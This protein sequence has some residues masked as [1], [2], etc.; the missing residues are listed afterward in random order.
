[1]FAEITGRYCRYK[2]VRWFCANPLNRLIDLEHLKVNDKIKRAVTHYYVAFRSG[3][4]LLTRLSDEEFIW[5]L[6]IY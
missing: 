4:Q 3:P 1:M 6:L 2:A 5:V